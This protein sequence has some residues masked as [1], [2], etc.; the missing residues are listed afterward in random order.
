M[1]NTLTLLACLYIQ[2]VADELDRGD[3]PQLSSTNAWQRLVSSFG[4][5]TSLRYDLLLAAAMADRFLREQGLLPGQPN[6]AG[7]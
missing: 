5:N 1:M 7:Q 6:D 3:E 2:F 4:E